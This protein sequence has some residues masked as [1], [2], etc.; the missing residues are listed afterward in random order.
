MKPSNKTKSEDIRDFINVNLNFREEQKRN[1]KLELY[2]LKPWLLNK[3]SKASQDARVH[4]TGFYLL[5]LSLWPLLFLPARFLWLRRRSREERG[6]SIY[7]VWTSCLFL[8]YSLLHHF[9]CAYFWMIL[10]EAPHRIFRAQ[11][12]T[13]HSSACCEE[14]VI[15]K[16]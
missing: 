8:R 1:K 12:Y 15:R 10:G 11:N 13:K 5:F 2:A 7:R 9:P 4:I 16:H 14:I 6:N 3:R